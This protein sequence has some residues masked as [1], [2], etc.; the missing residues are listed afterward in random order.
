M[1][2]SIRELNDNDV[3]LGRGNGPNHYEGNKRFRQLVESKK[4]LYSKSKRGEKAIISKQILETIH[5]R[6]G[7]FIKKTKK[8]KQACKER[9]DEW[10]EIIEEKALLEK[11]S[12]AFRD[13][14]RTEKKKEDCSRKS[15]LQ[16]LVEQ[17]ESLLENGQVLA[18]SSSPEPR[19]IPTQTQSMRVFR[20]APPKEI[21]CRR[22]S[23]P[24]RWH[25]K[26]L[27]EKELDFLLND[28][29][30]TPSG[31]NEDSA[32]PTNKNRRKSFHRSEQSIDQEHFS[33]KNKANHD[34]SE[35]S[36]LSW[37]EQKPADCVDINESEN[38]ILQNLLCSLNEMS[39]QNQ[40]EGSS[41]NSPLDSSLNIDTQLGSRVSL[42][43]F[44][45]DEKSLRETLKEDG[46]DHV[47]DQNNTSSPNCA[48]SSASLD[49]MQAFNTSDN[50]ISA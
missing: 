6:Q 8:N 45:D 22:K 14:L 3:L 27:E 50:S 30:P 19:P 23:L 41:I 12:M 49:I 10:K 26:L 31:T 15:K 25:K 11:I 13:A 38:A 33:K 47:G 40:E 29:T 1:M 35:N 2:N 17:Q 37:R 18:P 7:R 42:L 39:F 16:S 43:H 32:P 46:G 24:E 5:S 20:S 21:S 4:E 44:S 28:T 9:D 34:S 36:L 48:S